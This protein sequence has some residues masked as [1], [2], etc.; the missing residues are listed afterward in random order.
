LALLRRS[1]RTDDPN[2]KI[3]A[4]KHI[5]SKRR[6]PNKGALAS[7]RLSSSSIQSVAAATLTSPLSCFT[8]WMAE[9]GTKYIALQGMQ[10]GREGAVAVSADAEVVKFGGFAILCD[11]SL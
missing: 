8:G 11:R 4:G 6:K 3:K 10:L 5:C 9:F 7:A 2:A 1:S